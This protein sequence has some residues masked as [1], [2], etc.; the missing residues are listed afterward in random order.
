MKLNKLSIS[1]RKL[2]FQFGSIFLW[3]SNSEKMKVKWIVL[4]VLEIAIDIAL[5]NG[6]Q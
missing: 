5:L 1:L 6:F 2:L 3:L 4:I